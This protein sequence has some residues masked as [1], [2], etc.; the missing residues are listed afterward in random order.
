MHGG[1]HRSAAVHAGGGRSVHGART[2]TASLER[3]L[4]GRGELGIIAF[5]CALMPR[6][7]SESVATVEKNRGSAR[8]LVNCLH[9]VYVSL[10]DATIMINSPVRNSERKQ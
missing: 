2:A 6:V 10:N 9:A 1:A 4:T 5:V 7:I 3:D 8:H